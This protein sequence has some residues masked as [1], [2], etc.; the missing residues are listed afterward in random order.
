[1]QVVI[2]GH[3]VPISS[4]LHDFCEA[5]LK[6]AMHTVSGHVRAV[7]LVLSDVNGP[8]GGGCASRLLLTLSDGRQIV[9]ECRGNSFYAVSTR[10]AQRA[11]AR[12]RKD[13]ER[14]RTLGRE[15]GLSI[16]QHALGRPVQHS[17]SGRTLL[18]LHGTR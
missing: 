17:L 15:V 16:D 10:A 1:M 12:V 8:R 9:S 3:N 14:E 13:L 7:E 6:R 18:Q 11:V 5:Q 2:R 4:L